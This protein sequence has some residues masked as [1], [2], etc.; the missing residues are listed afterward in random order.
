M[1]G[2]EARS[3]AVLQLTFDDGVVG[4]VDLRASIQRGPYWEPLRDETS[5][6]GVSIAADGRSFGW[7]LDRLGEEIDFG[8]D[9]ARAGVETALVE[10]RADRY[11][12]RLAAAAQ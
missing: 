1:L 9:A 6:K 11:R 5:F 2:I 10:Q 3:D 7:R 12:R 4:P 8:V